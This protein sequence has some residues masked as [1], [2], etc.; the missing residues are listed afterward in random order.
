VWKSYKIKIDYYLSFLFDYTQ[1]T[2][3]NTQQA[4]HS[5]Q[6]TAHTHFCSQAT[7]HTAHAHFCTMS[8]FIERLTSSYK[9][10]TILKS[11]ATH[12]HIYKV[13]I[14][15]T[16]RFFDTCQE[17]F[18]LL[19]EEMSQMYIATMISPG[20]GR[21]I[22]EIR[23][24]GEFHYFDSLEECNDLLQESGYDEKWIETN[25]GFVLSL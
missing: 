12:R 25:N 18:D 23:L 13:K 21:T 6:H 9:H 5:T 1:H 20:T 15:S 22:F 4:T 19:E 14:G 7:Q 24:N 11:P 17:A 8:L 2:A 16:I 3:S 10:I